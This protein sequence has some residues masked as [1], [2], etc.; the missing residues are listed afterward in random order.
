[1]KFDE[2]WNYKINIILIAILGF[3]PII[4]LGWLIILCFDMSYHYYVCHH[5]HLCY[6]LISSYFI[7]DAFCFPKSKFALKN[8]KE[9]PEIIN[10]HIYGLVISLSA[11]SIAHITQEDSNNTY[12]LIC[13]MGN[14]FLEST[15]F[16]V[17][18]FG[19]KLYQ[20]K[21]LSK[22]CV[23]IRLTS[24]LAVFLL[25][26]YAM[27]NNFLKENYLVSFFWM[28]GLISQ[29]LLVKFQM[30]FMHNLWKRFRLL[31]PES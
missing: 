17:K 15:N 26:F 21:I 24:V 4:N 23:Y 1:M 30:V 28:S 18:V 5:N 29:G 16:A 19:K 11:L 2:I 9:V 25:V 13:Y 12:L 14:G 10:H 8:E 20:S 3:L 22:L 31:H 27:V 6:A 7:I